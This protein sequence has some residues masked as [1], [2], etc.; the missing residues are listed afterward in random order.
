MLRFL[1]ASAALLCQ[2]LERIIIL[3]SVILIVP[4]SNRAEEQQIDLHAPPETK[5]GTN[6]KCRDSFFRLTKCRFA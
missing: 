6:Q 5:I 2:N 4:D 1:P 3:R